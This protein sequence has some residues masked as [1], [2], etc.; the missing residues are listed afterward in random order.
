[1]SINSEKL[2]FYLNISENNT[3]TNGS[4]SVFV[5]AKENEGILRTTYFTYYGVGRKYGHGPYLAKMNK[6]GRTEALHGTGFQDA[7][8][9]KSSPNIIKH[10]GS[11]LGVGKDTLDAIQ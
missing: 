9:A 2:G 5:N 6:F 11:A 8:Q 1:M 3:K 4:R 10:F 7:D